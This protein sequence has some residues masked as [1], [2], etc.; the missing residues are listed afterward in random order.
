MLSGFGKWNNTAKTEKRSDGGPLVTI[1]GTGMRYA[2]SVRALLVFSLAALVCL[3]PWVAANR[4]IAAGNFLDDEG[5]VH[6]G[7]I[8]A[9]AIAGLTQGCNP[10]GN[11]FCPNALITREQVATFLVRALKLPPSGGDAYSDDNGTMHEDA[12]NR[13]T[14]A[15]IAKGCAAGSFCPLSQLTRGE[16]AVFLSRAFQLGNGSRDAYTDDGSSPF[17][18]DINRLAGAGITNGCSPTRFCPNQFVTRGEA[19]SFLAR[20]LGLVI[21]QAVSTNSSCQ[22]VQVV[23]GSN[24]VTVANSHPAGTTFC[25][26]AGTYNLGAS[27]PI[28]SNDKWIGALASGQRRS[29]ITGGGTTAYFTGATADRVL[30]QN[31]IIERFNNALQQGVNTGVQTFFTWDNVEVRENTGF[32]LHTWND[33]IIRNS[34]I[35]HNHQAGIGGQGDRVLIENNEISF[36]NYLQEH[37][38]AWEAGGSK[39]VNAT[40][41]T[42]RGNY[43]HDNHGPGLWSD[44]NNHNVVYENN[45]I[46]RNFG[47]GIHH[48]ISGSAVIRNNYIENTAHGYYRGGI[49]VA[50]SS[51]VDVYG[52]KLVANDGGVVVLENDRGAWITANVHVHDN[53]ITYTVGRSGIDGTAT[54]ISAARNNRFENNRYDVPNLTGQWWIVGSQGD[55]WAQ[56]QTAGYDDTGT[57]S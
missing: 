16:M 17:Q 53:N 26:A 14:S 40:D 46:I 43:V 31:V 1:G 34:F 37:D 10:S 3:S 33:S 50:N 41:L 32:G 4:A 45:R 57:A 38:P 35:H 5:S 29:T 11:N 12:I 2:K 21:A 6:E 19:A 18:D 15:G 54:T 39:W 47:P 52:N 36:N 7:A 20:G 30:I 28:Q 27:L 51:N 24:L 22:G 25:L 9:L 8:N 44:L 56:W 48:E 49:L 23:A 13:L 42:I 55:T